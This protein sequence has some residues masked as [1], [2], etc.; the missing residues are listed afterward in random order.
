MRATLPEKWHACFLDKRASLIERLAIDDGLYAFARLPER[1]HQ[2][3]L[4][5]AQS[6]D[7]ALAVAHTPERFLC[8]GSRHLTMTGT[9]HTGIDHPLRNRMTRNGPVQ[10][11]SGRG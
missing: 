6:P 3:L 10:S 9:D 2:L 4:T 11:G 5:I 1:E 7:C 8:V